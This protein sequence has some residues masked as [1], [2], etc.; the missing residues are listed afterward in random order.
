MIRAPILIVTVA[1]NITAELE[2]TMIIERSIEGTPSWLN[3]W[4]SKPR[5]ALVMAFNSLNLIKRQQS[6][7]HYKKSKHANLVFY[8]SLLVF[9]GLEDIYVFI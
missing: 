5:G 4:A 1:H 6:I 2:A 8:K 7:H 9:L 3:Y